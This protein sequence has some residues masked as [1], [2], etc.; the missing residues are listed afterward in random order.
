VKATVNFAA[1]RNDG[2]SFS[3][4]GRGET[5]QKLAPVLTEFNNARAMKQQPTLDKEGFT[6]AAHPRG[7]A[8]WSNPEWIQSQYI[9]SC[10]ELV[11]K[12]TGA[13]TV[14]PLEMT[15]QR[16]TDY[17]EHEGTSPTAGF[18]H[19]DL[20]RDAYTQAATMAADGFGVK[21]KKAAVYNIWKATTPPPQ[22]RPLAVCDQ[23]TVSDKDFVLGVTAEGDVNVPYVI[24]APSEKPPVWY[25]VPDLGLDESLVFVGGDLDPTHPLGC[26]HTAFDH[27]GNDGKPRASIEVRVLA[28]FE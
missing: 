8:E 7:R 3:N 13:K 25:Y 23:R 12:L 17:A 22:S 1:D 5:R 16:R 18:V 4:T 6:Y 9:P 14:L 20:P 11:K 28:C 19:L 2:G 15:V 21:F 26:A 24:L 27:P 10:V